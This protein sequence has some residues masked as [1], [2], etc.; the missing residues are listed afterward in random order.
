MNAL[1]SSN[2]QSFITNLYMKSPK[3]S[4]SLP[5]VKR[6]FPN[7]KDFNDFVQSYLEARLRSGG[8]TITITKDE[9][10]D[11]K[12]FVAKKAT[13]KEIATKWKKSRIYVTSRIAHFIENN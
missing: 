2:Y 12:A 4:F 3:N 1:G 6:V 11:I 5:I 8:R 9:E 13:I 10:R 7:Q